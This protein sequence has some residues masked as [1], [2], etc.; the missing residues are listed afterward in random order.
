VVGLALGGL[1]VLLVGVAGGMILA[2]TQIRDIVRE[3]VQ[4]IVE[5][6]TKSEHDLLWCMSHPDEAACKPA[7]GVRSTPGVVTGSPPEKKQ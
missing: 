4:P 5:E 3:E 6:V 1:L 7:T 2:M